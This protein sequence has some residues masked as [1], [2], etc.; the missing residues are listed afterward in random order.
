MTRYIVNKEKEKKMK[1]ENRKKYETMTAKEKREV[2][3]RWRIRKVSIYLLGIIF[4]VAGA[5]L[6]VQGLTISPIE[7]RWKMICGF[8]L[9]L[10]GMFLFTDMW[11]ERFKDYLRKKGL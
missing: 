2:L 3:K 6:F 8:F 4:I 9:M 7:H 5:I 11:N 10:V 1:A